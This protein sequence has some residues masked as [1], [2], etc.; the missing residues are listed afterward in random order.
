VVT[1]FKGSTV[2]HLR[3][4]GIKE[5]RH[6]PA[7]RASFAEKLPRALAEGLGVSDVTW[8]QAHFEPINN[9]TPKWIFLGPSSSCGDDVEY[10]ESQYGE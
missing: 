8:Y 7:W 3:N 5:N 4:K 1:K 10:G 6:K 9:A 2:P